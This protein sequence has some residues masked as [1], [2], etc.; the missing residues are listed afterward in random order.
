MRK[1][2]YLFL[3]A[4]LFGCAAHAAEPG[5]IESVKKEQLTIEQMRELEGAYA[6]ADGRTAQIRMIDDRL[7]L[8]VGR[9]GR[10]QLLAAGAETFSTRN[11]EISITFE[12]STGKAED[13]ITLS[14]NYPSKLSK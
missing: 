3:T 8:D 7:Y 1:L 13:K 10:W 2:P 14:Y 6:L 11:N 4:S 12:R 9:H 5:S